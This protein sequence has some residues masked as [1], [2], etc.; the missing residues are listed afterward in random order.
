MNFGGRMATTG[1]SMQHNDKREDLMVLAFLNWRRMTAC[2]I[3]IMTVVRPAQS[4]QT[5]SA[6]PNVAAANQ[7]VQSRLPFSDRQDFDDAMRGFIATTPDPANPDRWAFL[8][9]E[10]PPTV[11]PSLW[12]QAQL[13]ATNGLFKVADGVYQVRGFSQAN[14]TIVEG[15]T[16]LI[17][18]DTLTTPGA[19]REALNLYY[20]HCPRK[21]VLAVI[22]SH[23][24]G[25]H[26]G[27]A[28]GV[29][30]Q[31]DVAAGKTKIIAPAG[32]MQA[33]IGEAVI[34]G[35]AKARRAQYQ[36]GMP[37]PVGERGNVDE[38]LGK[39]DSRGA[40]GFGPIIA[41]NDTIQQPMETRTIDGVALI[42]QLALD[43]EAPSEMLIYLPQSHV[44]DVAEDATHTLH[45][46]LPFRG[47]VVRDANR[48]SQYLN[49]ALDQFGADAQ[50]L[51]AQHEW[52]VW[53]NERVQARLASQ[54][55]LY[56]Y[57]HDQ[58]IRMMNQ[59]LGP[60]EIAETLTMPPGLEND[61]SARGYYGTL[62]HNSKSVYQRYVGW[63]DGN[64]ATLNRL[65]RVEEAKKYLE[66]MG[67]SAAVIARARNDF[68]A[69]RYRWVAEVM[70]QV[71][72]ADPSNKEARSLA[73]DAFEQL[74]YLAE[75][76]T[77]RN[78]YLLGAQELRSGVGRGA[79]S[80][81]GISPETLHAMPISLVFDYLGTRIDGPRTGTANIVINWQFTD[82]H[83][84]LASTLEHGAL[85]SITDKN[86]P[87]AVTTVKTTRTVFESVILGRR[88][89]AD[90]MEQ[91][92]ITTVGDAKAVSD[93]LALLV[94]FEA[95]FPVVE[96]GR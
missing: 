29:V 58:T 93:L 35:N 9:R 74:G 86:A 11:N 13:N 65:P 76:A 87:N 85:T 15:T 12:R 79:R 4:Q 28:S 5:K 27:G 45:N 83:E 1:A 36:F 2:L 38:G 61:W 90:A 80:V 66:Y 55:D 54:R 68:K 62:S 72:F 7:A 6:E 60:T 96:P 52:P 63:Y 49:A 26:Y 82:T 42:F 81:P 20:V 57:V 88:T 91:R 40:S 39:N 14:M 43:S 59:G 69:G 71:V 25:D 32:F 64:P 17:V 44:L 92:E 50:V 95:G 21:P 77:W 10:A 30:S 89:L 22:Y 23:S 53:G 34:G 47:T 46:L 41:P 94:D 31:A 84:S 48:W 56:K 8:E 75:S 3:A 33:V 19:A 18:I 16:G 24:H 51:I 73:A 37:L 78:A 70:D 67:G